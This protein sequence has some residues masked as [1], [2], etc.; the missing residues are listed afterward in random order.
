MTTRKVQDRRLDSRKAR[1]KLKARGMPYY[2]KIEGDLA[3]GF[4]RLRG[5]AG[6]WGCRH[7][8]GEGKYQVERLGTADD[9][10]EAFGNGRVDP[11][12]L[13]LLQAVVDP[14]LTFD[15]AQALARGGKGRRATGAMSGPLTVNDAVEQYLDRLD[16]EGSKSIDDAR[17]RAA[18][19][20]FPAK[21]AT[22]EC[23]KLTADDLHRWKAKLAKEAPRK[24]T[25]KDGKQQH[26]EF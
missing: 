2:R 19:F 7:Y 9:F 6:T 24:R 12:T 14:V 5:Q 15:Q 16:G 17:Y 4:R 8:M 21:I 13:K 18:A 20:I 26:R 25:K 1:E 11:Q 10:S 23:N 22:I 3:V